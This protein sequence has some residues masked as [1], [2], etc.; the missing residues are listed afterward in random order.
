MSEQEALA[1]IVQQEMMKAGIWVRLHGKEGNLLHS[2]FVQPGDDEAI[3][4]AEDV[5]DEAHFLSL[6]ING[7]EIF[8]HAAT[9]LPCKIPEGG[10][11]VLNDIKTVLRDV[12]MLQ[13]LNEMQEK[14]NS[15]E[16]KTH[17]PKTDR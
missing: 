7:K 4:Y 1:W 8:R 9:G 10:R 11:L 2:V 16:E 12:L 13:S 15:L 5:T 3:F 14:V 6:A 17:V